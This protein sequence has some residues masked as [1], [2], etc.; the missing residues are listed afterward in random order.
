VCFY[1]RPDARQEEFR[2]WHG[3]RHRIGSG[4]VH[5]ELGQQGIGVG[6]GQ[7]ATGTAG[8]QVDP[9]RL[10]DPLDALEMR[11]AGHHD[12]S[13]ALLETPCGEAPDCAAQE[14]GVFVELHAV[15]CPLVGRRHFLL[16]LVLLVPRSF[17][18]L[19][20]LLASLRQQ[21]LKLH[22]CVVVG[23]ANRSY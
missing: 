2:V 7:L 4:G 13:L 14:L 23:R 21:R 11:A 5:H 10:Q 9:A 6:R 17:G 12:D 19:V 3:G 8:R 20:F 16:V 15:V 1:E 18:V 22:P